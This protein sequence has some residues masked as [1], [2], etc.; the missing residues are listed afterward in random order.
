MLDTYF[1]LEYVP[2]L[3]SSSSSGKLLASKGKREV[4]RPIKNINIANWSSI[5]SP[6]SFHLE[7]T[8][9]VFAAINTVQV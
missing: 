5:V 3:W 1:A 2:Q 8:R 7:Y 4:L 6:G 9:S